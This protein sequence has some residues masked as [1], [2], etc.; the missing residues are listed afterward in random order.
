[1]TRHVCL[2]VPG[3]IA[4]FTLVVPVSTQRVTSLSQTQT[5]SRKKHAHIMGGIRL[6]L[7]LE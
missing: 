4:A 6:A 3:T 1:M 2:A 5:G 7:G